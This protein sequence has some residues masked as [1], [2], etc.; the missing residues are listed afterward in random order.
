MKPNWHSLIPNSHPYAET[1]I[2]V[3]FCFLQYTFTWTLSHY[4]WLSKDTV[5]YIWD[6]LFSRLALLSC[7]KFNFQ[8]KRRCLPSFVTTNSNFV[9][10]LS[11]KQSTFKDCWAISITFFSGAGHGDYKT[12][13]ICYTGH[14]FVFPRLILHTFCKHTG[15]IRVAGTRHLY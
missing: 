11:T 9:I 4:Q 14:C 10:E 5:K 15:P 6:T 1:D 13:N 2:Q 12:L 3:H 7:H 8:H